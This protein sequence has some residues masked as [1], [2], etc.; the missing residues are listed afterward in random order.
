MS[1]SNE[2]YHWRLHGCEWKNY[3]KTLAQDV[4]ERRWSL[5]GVK[6]LIKISVR[7]LQLCWSLQWCGHCVVDHNPN[8]RVS[9]ATAVT[10]FVKCFNPL[11]LYLHI[12][13]KRFASYFLFINEHLIII[14]SPTVNFIAVTTPLLTSGFHSC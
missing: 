3:V 13:R 4:F 10:F 2:I 12:F 11:K 9:D 7:D 6:T 1:Y 8:T 14:W 5:G